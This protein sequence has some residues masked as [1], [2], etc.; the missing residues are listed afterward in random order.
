METFIPAEALL[1]RRKHTDRARPKTLNI[2]RISRRELELGRAEFP[3][4]GYDRPTTRENCQHGP[5]A[6]RPCPFVGCKHHLYLD[7]NEKNGSIKL[8]F[9]DLEV[10][11]LEE[12]CG[13]DVADAGEVTLERVCELTNLEFDRVYAIY[14][15]ALDSVSSG[16]V[17][18]GL[19]ELLDEEPVTEYP[20]KV[21]A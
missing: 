19:C 1:G 10:W 13:L 4:E 7:V 21:A 9:P 20:V 17:R 11:E 2:A 5:H 15:A 18:A 3:D 16:A 14:R 12:T 8:N 6:E